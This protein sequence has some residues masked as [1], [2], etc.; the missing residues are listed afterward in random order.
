MSGDLVHTER[1]VSLLLD[2]AVR[3]AL[4]FWENWGRYLEGTL[5]IRR[6]ELVTGPRVLRAALDAFRETGWAMR[7]PEFLGILAESLIGAG[8]IA[9]PLAMID[10]ALAKAERDEE[11]WCLAELLRVRAEL[12]LR[13]GGS[14]AL[15]AAES[16]LLQALDWARRQGALSWELRAATSLARLWYRDKRPQEARDILAPLYDR[17]SEGFETADLR[18]AQKLLGHQ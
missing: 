1:Y 18:A 10:A 15:A 6:G 13:E 4:T 11:R 8:Q 3:H 7:A 5:L 2:V 12:W 16:G 9:E 14:S 17:F